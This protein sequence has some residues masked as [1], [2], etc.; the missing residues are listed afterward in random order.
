MKNDVQVHSMFDKMVFDPSLPK[1]AKKCLK[2]IKY[3]FAI[4][5]TRKAKAASGCLFFERGYNQTCHCYQNLQADIPKL[6][7]KFHQN[8]WYGFG[9][10][11]GQDNDIV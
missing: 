1:G 8:L 6:H 7:V 11:C 10:K 4:S 2:Y 3:P 9:E 5:K